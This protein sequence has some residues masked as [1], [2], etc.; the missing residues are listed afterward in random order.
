MK[1]GTIVQITNENDKW[2]PCLLV[3]DEVKGFGVQGYITIPQKGD[4]YYRVKTGDF[5]VVGEA[6]VVTSD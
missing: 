1:K 6:K 3:V 4:A 5:E 2:F